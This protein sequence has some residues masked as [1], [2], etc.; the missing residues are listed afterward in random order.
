LERRNSECV[1]RRAITFV[2]LYFTLLL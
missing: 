1:S 2:R